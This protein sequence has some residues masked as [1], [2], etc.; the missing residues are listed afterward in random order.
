VMPLAICAGSMCWAT[1]ISRTVCAARIF[2][3][4][5]CPW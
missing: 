1:A 4:L 2:A 5:F 3:S